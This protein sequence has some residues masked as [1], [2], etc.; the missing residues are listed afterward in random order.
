[1]V[2]QAP[3]L[4][5]GVVGIQDGHVHQG[6]E[7]CGLLGRLRTELILQRQD[8]EAL[9]LVGVVGDCERAGRHDSGEEPVEAD[10]SDEVD[11][12]GRQAERHV[13]RVALE[14]GSL[15]V[16][17][18]LWTERTLGAATGF[19]SGVAETQTARALA[20]THGGEGLELGLVE[21]V[22]EEGV[23]RVVG[24]ESFLE[25]EE[26]VHVVEDPVEVG[27]QQAGLDVVGSL[28]QIWTIGSANHG[29]EIV[30]VHGLLL[31]RSD[32]SEVPL[33]VLWPAVEE[34]AN[35]SNLEKQ[36]DVRIYSFLLEQEIMRLLEVLESQV[37]LGQLAQVHDEL[38][39]HVELDSPPM[40]LL[41]PLED[42][43]HQDF[44]LGGPLLGAE[45]RV[46]GGWTRRV[47]VALGIASFE[48]HLSLVEATS[49]DKRFEPVKVDGSLRE[50]LCIRDDVLPW[51]FYCTALE[52]S[53]EGAELLKVG[54]L[55]A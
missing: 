42:H 15:Q 38:A 4:V 14:V 30:L 2:R 22:G 12:V 36:G 1:M 17:P 16:L 45:S 37:I 10:L 25:Q 6:G 13:A 47:R 48:N 51:N 34:L 7:L 3:D 9:Q 52:V 20:E 33:L 50:W 29:F 55:F 39:G 18:R 53:Q 54:G 49:V 35:P 43:I 26:V 44:E 40:S 11:E 8:E 23:G 27:A 28:L 31:L 19:E 21:G 41:V 46:V 32:R 5:H 24:C